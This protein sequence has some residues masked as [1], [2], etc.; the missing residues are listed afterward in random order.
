MDFEME[1]WEK[2]YWFLRLLIPELKVDGPE[3]G[4]IKDLLDDV[5]LY[6]YGLRRTALNEH[7]D[8]A[9][10]TAVIDP[11]KAKMVNAGEPDYTKDPLDKILDEFNE[12]HFKGW[13][14]TPDDQKTKLISIAKSVAVDNDYQTLVVG[15]PDQNATEAI[16]TKIID[17]II[18]QKRKDDMSLY[19]EYQKNDDFKYNMRN[20][21]TRMLGNAD[22]LFSYQR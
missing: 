2:M 9:A 4:G 18:R 12:H 14:A 1:D 20:V 11:T 17:R 10:E 22:Y 21:I 19:R 16:M 15:N 13:E 7:I 8:L 3:S 6:T 5:D